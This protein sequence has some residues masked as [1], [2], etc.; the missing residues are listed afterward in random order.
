MV[1]TAVAMAT[2]VAAVLAIVME[3]VTAMEVATT[4]TTFRIALEM[5]VVAMAVEL[6]WGWCLQ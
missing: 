5:T 6:Q 4:V 1:E 3:M 2:V